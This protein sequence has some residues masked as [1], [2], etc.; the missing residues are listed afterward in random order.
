MSN[1]FNDS[2]IEAEGDDRYGITP[3]AS[4]LARS[5]LGIKKPVGTTLALSGPWGSGKSSAVNL[6]RAEL[7]KARADALVV[8]DFKCWWYRGE[9]ALALAFLQHLNAVLR[10]NFGDKVKDLVP[11]LTRGLLQ[12][13]PVV[14]TAISVATG[15]P[16]AALVPS[17]S[18]YVG[19]LFP[20]G[21]TVEKTFRKLA[22]V[23]EG[24]QRRFLIIIDDI[25]RLTPEESLAIFRL[26]KSVGRL[27]NVVYLL[28][29]DR[30]LA[31]K[32]V[33]QFYPSEGPHFL[34]KIIQAGFEL[35]LPLQVDLNAALLTA[36]QRVCGE[37]D[38][39][40]V[41]RI[42]NLYYD[43]IAPHATTP[44]HVARY[45]NAISVTWPAITNEID[46]A[47]FLALEAIRLYEPGLF[48]AIRA[49]KG[50]LCGMRQQGDA[51][52][53]NEGRF[54]KYL[55]EVPAARHD[56]AKAALQRLFPR[57]EGIGYSG[58]FARIWDMERRVCI[59][60]HFDTYFRASLSKEALSIS[61]INDLVARAD[62]TPFIQGAMR[63]AAATVRSNGKSLV[64]VYLEELTTHA[65]R[66][67]LVKVGALFSALFAIHDE[68][69]LERDAE[70]G[71]M[72]I[73]NTTF[74]YH[75]LIRAITRDRCNIDQRTA[76]YVP[77]LENA[78][79]G[80]LVDFTVSAI[81][82]Y[83]PKKD[84]V[85][86]EEDWLVT[87]EA[88]T[89]LR[90]H[91]LTRIR[92]ASASGVLLHH[93]DLMRVLYT[94]RFLMNEDSTE[95]RRW[96][97]QLMDNDDAL[98][99]FAKEMTGQSW[100]F[101]MGGFGSLGDRVATPRTEAH[102]NDDTDILDV[103][104]FRTGL[105]RIVAEGRLD[106]GDREAVRTFLTA[107]DRGNRQRDDD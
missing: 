97:D 77:A 75:W 106:E 38:E 88:L 58:E 55:V 98:V 50:Q 6:I 83:E 15:Q 82:Q 65:S 24:E 29:F 33:L 9:E 41:Q 105:D 51:E 62:D 34:E 71:F 32:T 2:P 101:G 80:W 89:S 12:A 22:R 43:V 44:R 14:G 59:E 7:A 84:R 3:F 103:A 79:L 35:P 96:T 10:D 18:K 54:D 92:E 93:R 61:V 72:G 85:T 1:Y 23:L 28:V 21:D 68:I 17:A 63:E 26:V 87:E 74:R 30:E 37:P 60:R 99:V 40:Q 16:W 8:T 11:S 57:M 66:V 25:D 36:I 70:K 20:K 67:E 45:E 104:A 64:P 107:W 48:R 81:R 19:A 13:G 49:G 42:M 39:R 90:E 100:S 27:P 73:A 94:W 31:E 102:I 91:A 46:L 4:S 76:L 52:P 95:V 86:P 78:C 53:R 5:I 47:D 69:D 56:T